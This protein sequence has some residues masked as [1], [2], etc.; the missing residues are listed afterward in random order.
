MSEPRIIK[1]YPNRRLY[2]TEVSSYITLDD[3][4]KLVQAQADFRVVDARSG[5]DLT[6]SILLQ[7]IIEQEAD[8]EPIF[9]VDVLQQI[10][11]CYGDAMQG[12]VSNWFEQSLA[13]LQEQQKAYGERMKSMLSGDPLSM[14]RTITSQNLAMWKEVQER[15]LRAASGTNPLAPG[16]PGAREDLGKDR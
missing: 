12:L 11:R 8:G 2:D 10:I 13:L 1:K 4:R 9:S 6:R 5:E 7:I 3:V 14:V 16:R 15:F